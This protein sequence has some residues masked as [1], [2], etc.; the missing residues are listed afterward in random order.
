MKYGAVRA[1]SSTQEALALLSWGRMECGMSPL[2]A[3]RADVSC[4][5]RD[6]AERHVEQELGL[7]SPSWRWLVQICHFRGIFVVEDF[8]VLANFDVLG[9]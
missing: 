2:W 5:P 6:A 8:E 9:M 1:V 4:D 3:Q 7:W